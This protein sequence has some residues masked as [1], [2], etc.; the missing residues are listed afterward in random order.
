MITPS[1][2]SVVSPFYA[3]GNTPAVSLTRCLPQVV[4][5]DILL[6][7]CGDVRN[8]LYTAYTESGFRE[9]EI[10]FE[11]IIKCLLCGMIAARR[12]DITAC[13]V[14][15]A[16]IGRAPSLSFSLCTCSVESAS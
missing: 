9:Y 7:G 2:L 4:D 13:D 15:D 10:V 16:I 11:W 6:L 12:L 5:A 8:I 14:E 3:V 1:V